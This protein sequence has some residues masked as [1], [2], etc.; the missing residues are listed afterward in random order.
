MCAKWRKGGTRGAE[1]PQEGA[2]DKRRPSREG[3]ALGMGERKDTGHQRPRRE[4]QEE[5][6]GFGG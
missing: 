6:I 2:K 1:G 4:G 5:A 3:E